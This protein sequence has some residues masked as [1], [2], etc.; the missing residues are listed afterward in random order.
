[1]TTVAQPPA[2]ATEAEWQTELARRAEAI[3][4]ME[5]TVTELDLR[6]PSDWQFDRDE[7]NER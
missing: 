1:M 3:R 7:A 6:F 2:F 4:R 5:K